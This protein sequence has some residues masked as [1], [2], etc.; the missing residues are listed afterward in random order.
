MRKDRRA[1]VAP[2]SFLIAGNS[3]AIGFMG[4]GLLAADEFSIWFFVAAISLAVIA[5]SGSLIA[6]KRLAPP[7]S[8]D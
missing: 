7:G 5:T 8:P 2:L 6:I 1:L 3:V 4:V